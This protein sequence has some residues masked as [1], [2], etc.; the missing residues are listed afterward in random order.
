MKFEDAIE[1][2]QDKKLD[3][4]LT[5]DV[6]RENLEFWEKAWAPVKAAYTKLP[7][8]SYLSSIPET[9]KA[10]KAETVL[11]L[12]CGT[13]W[14]SV[15]LSREGFSL[16]GVD[17]SNHAIKLAREWADKE[18]LVIRFDVC[19]L[20]D[21]NYPDSSFDA[22]V[23]NSIFEHFPLMVT[24]TMVNRIRR[25]LVPGGT[26]IGCFDKVGGGP[27]QYFELPDKT[28]VYTDKE[29]KGMLLRY[30]TN[31][32]LKEIFKPWR[33]ETLA[34]TDTGTRVLTART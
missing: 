23:G 17:I 22:V 11:D 10:N 15:Y 24:Q 2:C 14:L 30:Y 26:F 21:L 34:E 16:T 25:I 18:D 33:I 9:L 6:Y 19:D 31:E 12:G 1:P 20:A 13:G 27:G 8:L 29:R 3:E 28:H 32:E 7:S 4:L 5:S